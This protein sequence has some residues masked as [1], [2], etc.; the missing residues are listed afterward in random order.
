MKALVLAAG[1][2]SRLKPWTEHHPKALA[3]VG[4]VPMLQRVIEKL[5]ESGINDITVNVFHF[6]DQIIDFIKAKGWN[7]NISD[8]RPELLETGGAILK[9]EPFLSGDEPILVHNADIL[10]NADF[11][12]IETAHL[13]RNADAT[14]LVS[15]RSSSR[16]LI[17]N[18]QQLKGWHNLSTDEYRPE[19][20]NLKDRQ[21][22]LAFSGI[23]LISPKLIEEMKRKGFEGRFSIID[24]FLYSIDDIKI[25]G[26]V[27]PDLMLID[28]GKPDSL[29]RANLLF[30]DKN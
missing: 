1:V 21:T 19:G 5:L 15:N 23:Y 27:Q 7:I 9:A 14:L 24:F 6:A 17:F 12:E 4:G 18:Q 2:G 11:G 3:P 8:E 16:K 28:I 13:E 20:F 10:S 26:Y 22:E 29:N 30:A 25:F